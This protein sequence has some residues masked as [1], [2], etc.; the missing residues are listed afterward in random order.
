MLAPNHKRILRNTGMLYIRM[1]LV[2]VVT[3][4]TSRVVLAVLGVEDFGIYHV[5]AGFVALL[6]F[7]QGAMTTATQRYFAFD[8]G[9]SDGKDLNRIFNTSLLI[10]GLL[11]LI[12]VLVAETAG[13]W[14][15]ATQLTIP[16]ERMTAALWPPSVSAY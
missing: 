12:I 10:H 11:A 16:D 2:M 15:V 4:Y 9:E 7:M 14:F 1:L 3:L 13:Y 5:V 8:L 6:G